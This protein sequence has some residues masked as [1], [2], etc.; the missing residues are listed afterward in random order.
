[1]NSET[2]IK[3][4]IIWIF[5]FL[6]LGFLFLDRVLFPIALFEFPNELEWDTS[7]WYNFLHKR[8]TFILK[9]M[10]REFS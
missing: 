1:M 10:K 5:L 7:P 8:K 4:K 3:I 9:K 6:L 2:R